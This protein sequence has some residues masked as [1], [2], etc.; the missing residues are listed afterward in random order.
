MKRDKN[1]LSN[2]CLSNAVTYNSECSEFSVKRRLLLN[3]IIF[4]YVVTFTDILQLCVSFKY[5]LSQFANNQGHI[6]CLWKNLWH[7]KGWITNGGIS[8]IIV[9]MKIEM[10]PF[11]LPNYNTFLKFTFPLQ[12]LLAFLTTISS[13]CPTW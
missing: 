4:S 7:S 1:Q 9:A 5:G 13:V 6:L 10:I 2:Y 8:C 11:F 12:F 3:H